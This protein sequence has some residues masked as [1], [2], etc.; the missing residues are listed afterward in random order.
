[1]IL[2]IA[3]IANNIPTQYI[4]KFT[5]VVGGLSWSRESSFDR[6]KCIAKQMKEQ[7]TPLYKKFPKKTFLS[8]L[9]TSDSIEEIK[10]IKEVLTIVT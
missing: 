4:I 5:N 7:Y 1:M 10:K 6:L 3:V 9:L 8:S 2:K